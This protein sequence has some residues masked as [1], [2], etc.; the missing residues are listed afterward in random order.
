MKLP[1]LSTLLMALASS[2]VSGLW[3]TEYA[4]QG[5]IRLK[6]GTPTSEWQSLMGIVF[7]LALSVTFWVAWLKAVRD[8]R[9]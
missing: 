6:E 5:F 9:K 2:T 4:Q 1:K 7:L 3:I 8:T